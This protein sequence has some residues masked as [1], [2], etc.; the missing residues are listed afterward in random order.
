[1]ADSTR[2]SLN[3]ATLKSSSLEQCIEACARHSI[4]GISPWRDTLAE[5]GVARAARQIRDAGLQVSG[6]CRGG[7]FTAA[8]AAERT[9]ALDDNRRAIDE[10]HAIGAHCLVLVVGGVPPGSRDLRGAHEMIEDAISTLLP[11]ARA[12]GV[13]LAIEPLHPMYAADRACVNTLKHANDLCDRLGN[14]LGVAVDVYHLWW[15]AELEREIARAGPRIHAFHVCD[16]LR[17]T[18]DLL[19]DRGMMGDGVIDVPR[20]RNWV[21]G[22]GYTGLLEVEIFSAEDWWKRGPDEV[23]EAVKSRIETAV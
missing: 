18:R 20:I 9:A 16:W 1:M 17:N 10:A 7:M 22:A 21:E 3:T 4:V 6:L 2:I 11:I 8:S 14:G 12:A 13:P 5:M 19:L 23:L 15:D